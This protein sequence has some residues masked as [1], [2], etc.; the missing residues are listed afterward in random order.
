MDIIKFAFS[1]IIRILIQLS[2]VRYF[3]QTRSKFLKKIHFFFCITLREPHKTKTHIKI[4]L[5]KVMRPPK[6]I[7][8]RHPF[9]FHILKNRQ[10]YLHILE[11]KIVFQGQQFL[12]LNIKYDNIIISIS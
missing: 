10:I 6:N 2:L 11:N 4:K 12:Y 9:I 8:N 3:L 5:E 7:H 1:I